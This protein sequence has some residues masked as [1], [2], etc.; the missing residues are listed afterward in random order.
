MHFIR[1]T[2][3]FTDK[4]HRVN[5]LIFVYFYD[6][7]RINWSFRKRLTRSAWLVCNF[8]LL[9][10]KCTADRLMWMDGWKAFKPFTTFLCTL[11]LYSVINDLFTRTWRTYEIVKINVCMFITQKVQFNFFTLVLSPKMKLMWPPSVVRVGFSSPTIT[12]TARHS[13]RQP[14]TWR[15]ASIDL[16]WDKCEGLHHSRSIGSERSY[17]TSHSH[18]TKWKCITV[19]QPRQLQQ[20][21]TNRSSHSQRH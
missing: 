16:Y 7:L 3:R 12:P 6:G 20:R 2:L 19:Q 17:P 14:I 8:S 9:P 18:H 11:W 5:F 15:T 13:N 4:K 21:Q 1:Y 10:P